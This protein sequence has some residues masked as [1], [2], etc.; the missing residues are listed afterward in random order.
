MAKKEKQKE[1]LK[2]EEI[3]E[4]N[5]A[6]IT[7]NDKET[8]AKLDEK[9]KDFIAT[10]SK[11]KIAVV[12]PLFGYWSTISNNPLTLEVFKTVM[13]RVTSSTHD[14]YIIYVAEDAKVLPII[15]KT[16]GAKAY[17]GNVLGVSVPNG[18]SYSDYLDEGIYAA[19]NET[20][21]KFVVCLNPWIMLQYNAIDK[22]VDRVNRGD[23]MIVSG[24][25]TRT[26]VEAERFDSHYYDLPKEI[27]AI[28]IN[29][30][31]MA[32]Y[33][34]DMIVLD[35]AIKTHTFVAKDIWQN[36]YKKGYEVIVSQSIPTFSFD[37]D[38]SMYEAEEAYVNDRVAFVK[39]WGFD[40][41]L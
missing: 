24:F 11:S 2:R 13:D 4:A 6:K 1:V 15:A 14:M 40:P 37:I 30:F 31:G 10:T 8:I 17:G 27:R 16:I 38:W 35:P 26:I 18:S 39:K 7:Q 22:L 5:Q 41:E 25:D 9:L 34:A 20:D 21:S 36:F 12:V 32:R 28:D 33:A 3:S 19:L 23:V 29:F